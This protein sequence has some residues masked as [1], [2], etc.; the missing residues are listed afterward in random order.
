MTE[1]SFYKLRLSLYIDAHKIV[2]NFCT[3]Y[4]VFCPKNVFE[5]LVKTQRKQLIINADFAIATM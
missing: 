5:E 1:T 4:N 2:T 3:R